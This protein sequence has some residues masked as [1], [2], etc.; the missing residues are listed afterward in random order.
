MNKFYNK[1]DTSTKEV[2]DP[3]ELYATMLAK[4]RLEKEE[5]EK[6]MEEAFMNALEEAIKKESK[7]NVYKNGNISFNYDEKRK[8]YF[9]FRLEKEE[10]DERI[11]LYRDVQ[12]SAIDQIRIMR[13]CTSVNIIEMI[14][15]L[16]YGKDDWYKNY[17]NVKWNFYIT[18]V[19]NKQ[20]S[21]VLKVFNRYYYL[22]TEL[23]KYPYWFTGTHEAYRQL[24]DWKVLMIAYDRLLEWIPTNQDKIEDVRQL[25]RK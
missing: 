1:D 22:D 5:I 9:C 21:A 13:E 15:C 19:V 20:S 14:R 7:Y 16:D 11:Y 10:A 25:S 2:K 6:K 8:L 18:N 23:S 12:D 17:K 4:S 24:F 3:M